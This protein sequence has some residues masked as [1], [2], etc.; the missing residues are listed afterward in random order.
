MNKVIHIPVLLEETIK[1]L[2][3]KE[4][5]VYVDGTCGYGGHSKEILKRLSTK[6]RLIAI[7]R[8]QDAI[9]YLTKTLKRDK[10]V[11][12]VHDN[13]VN[14]AN[15]LNELGIKEIDGILL[16]LGVSSKMLD[17]PKRGF[18][19]RFDGPLDM[20]FDRRQ[21]LTARDI[22]NNA[23]IKTLQDIFVKNGEVNAKE[24]Y[25]VASNIVA[26]R[27]EKPIDSTLELASIIK[28]AVHIKKQF[29]GK[30]PAKQYFQALRIHL[31]NELNVID[32]TLNQV[33]P[34]I[35]VG[36]RIAIISF[37]SLEDRIVKQTFKNFTSSKIPKFLPIKENDIEFT[38][39]N[40]KPIIATEDELKEN[41]R[42]HSAKLRA[43]ER[44]KYVNH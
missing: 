19:Y 29:V 20:R 30:H 44:I 17:D 28:E 1:A 15:I 35:K 4:D 21:D 42:S 7:D 12:L 13:F 32:K 38:L 14:I 22:V 39:V 18:S 25:Y 33:K 3:I 36:G 24:A 31:N 26:A 8:D 6:G 5:G 9:D 43:I 2:N 41:N 27:N 16:D 34:F 23:S 40:K 37:H 10:R 11:T